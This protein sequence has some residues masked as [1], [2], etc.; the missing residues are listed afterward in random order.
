MRTHRSRTH[1]ITLL[2]PLFCL[3][4]AG[5]ALPVTAQNPGPA[6][7]V[8]PHSPGLVFVDYRHLDGENNGIALM[9]LDP[10]SPQFG[11]ILQQYEMD[12]GVLPHHLYFN[13]AQDRLY[14]S[15]LTGSMLYEVNLRQAGKSPPRIESTTP[16]DVGGST[17]GEDLYFT[18]DGTRFYM[19]FM[20]GKGG[21]TGGTVGVF[22]AQTNELI[23]TIEAPVPA[24]PSSGQPFILYPHGLSANEEIGLLMVTSATHPDLVSGAGNTVTAIDMQTNKPVKTYLVA[25]DWQTLSA[26][27][28]VLLLRDELPPF[29]L[30]TTLLTG[31]IWVAGYNA[32]TGL[33]DE[34]EKKVE[35]E[36]SDQ[37]WPLEFYIHKNHH[38]EYELYVTFGAPGVINVYSLDSLPE[39]P[40]KRT[41]PAAAG[42]H[43]M[44]FFETAS[45]REVVVVQ[46]NLLHI[47]G[48]SRGTLMVLDIETGEVLG[49]LDLPAEHNLMPESIESAY[50]HGHDYHH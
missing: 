37:A 50:G 28:E 24:D 12:A 31:D 17:V 3:I 13:A 26:P 45:G 23:E 14:N 1:F 6:Q 33:F 2:V 48:L 5:C 20:G 25:E 47:D 38:G 39:L 8:Q 34:F 7:D 49:D 19:T 46:N 15:T 4:L 22:D 35:G 18:Q 10:E 41:L 9:D 40:L 30:V 16:I 36:A 11:K 42:A 32:E 21:P 29:A 27:V 43:H 44:V